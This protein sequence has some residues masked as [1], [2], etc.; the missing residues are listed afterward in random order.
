MCLRVS[1]QNMTQKEFSIEW[2]GKTLTLST[3]KLALQAGGAVLAQYGDT[4]VL[5]TAT[6]GKLREGIDFFPL[7]VEF[8][9]RLDAAGKIKSSRFIKR[10]GRPTD[11]AILSS[12]LIDRAVR[13]L[14]NNELRNEIQVVATCLSFDGEN[15]PDVLGL[16]AASAALSISNVPWDGPIGGC[17]VGRVEGEF[18]LNPSYEARLKSDTD[19]IVAGTPE[20]VIMLEAGCNQVNEADAFKAISF[21]QKHLR[22]VVELINKMQKEIGKEKTS[23]DL[24]NNATDE[25]RAKKKSL[26]E[27]VHAFLVPNIDT[28]FFGAPKASKVDRY[29]AKKQLHVLLD[30]HLL[31]KAIPEDDHKLAHSFVEEVVEEAV[32]AAI[33]HNDRRVDGRKIDEVRTLGSEVGVLPR[34]HGSGLFSRGDTQILSTVTLGSPGDVQILDGMRT[35]GKKRYMHHYSFPAF[36]V[37][38]TGPMRGPGRREI[39]HGALAER[40][41]EPVLPPVEK[42]PY[43]IRVVSEVLGSNGSSSMGSSC[44]SSLALMDAGV[45]ITAPVG[46]VA[47]GIATEDGSD[48]YKI[49]TDLQDL[50]DGKGGMDFKVTGTRAGITAIQMDTKTKGL[51]S[52]IV[53]ETLTRALA[54][55]M[56]VLDVMDACLAAPRA[57]LSK[58]APR[59]ETIMINP[60]KIRDVIGPGGKMINEIIAATG[61][62]I[63]V[64]Q[65]GRISVTCNKAEGLAKAVE[66]IK[67]ITREVTVGEIIRGKVVRIMDFGA[68]V[69]LTPN[70]D[71]MAHISQLAPYRVAR[72][73]DVVKLGDEVPVK[74][75]EIDDLG[76]IN[77]SIKAAREEL[78]EPQAQPPAGYDPN[79]M[80]SR[81]PN[82]GPRRN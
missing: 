4:V 23:I 60:E 52:K 31:E 37:G 22:E 3:G 53:E 65:D 17:R 66:W 45:P 82:R 38:E 10:E 9:E 58:W 51:T 15:D 49:I 77:L 6:M 8:E 41:L 24:L 57:E 80:P 28:L 62:Q 68:F 32:S 13:P 63:D 48:K 43:T 18:V 69:Q 7:Q 21:G 74:V 47:M 2:G 35:V 33:L 55:R 11:E 73:E 54:G 25:T 44:G 16:V 75:I 76:R 72:V 20:K 50:E 27:S 46:G 61:A 26:K 1:H 71:G 70:Q 78:G 5:A 14:F 59:I 30:A 12:R 56:K 79:A 81:P 39:G 40:A 29:A 36:S 67:N 34:T 19:I 64:E 42:F